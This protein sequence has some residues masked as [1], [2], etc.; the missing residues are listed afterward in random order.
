MFLGRLL[1]VFRDREG[2]KAHKTKTTIH[3]CFPRD[4]VF[5]ESCPVPRAFHSPLMC[6]SGQNLS[7]LFWETHANTYMCCPGGTCC[8]MSNLPSFLSG[9]VSGRSCSRSA[10]P[11]PGESPIAIPSL[12][13]RPGWFHS[14]QPSSKAPQLRSLKR[15]EK[16]FSSQ[17]NSVQQ[18]S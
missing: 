13:D 2:I 18:L 16:Y 9:A 12:A 15:P 1:E 14:L 17:K 5:Q 8:W 4:K 3:M 10:G 7:G 11:Y 6:F